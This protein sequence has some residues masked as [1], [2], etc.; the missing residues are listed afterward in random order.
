MNIRPYKDTDYDEILI[1][2]QDGG[3]FDNTWDSRAHW[4]AKIEKDFESILV[5]EDN[6]E[7]IGCILIIKDSWTC[8]LFRLAVKQKYQEKGIGS[9]L[10]TSAEELLRKNG[11]EEVAIFVS[12]DNLKLHQYY[13]KRGYVKGGKYRCFYKKL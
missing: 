1:I 13:E 12:E 4:K 9:L 2:L 5:A 3:H 6:N 11:N 10:I 8:F 7:I